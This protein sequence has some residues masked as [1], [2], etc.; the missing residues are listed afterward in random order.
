ELALDLSRL[1][2]ATRA[3]GETPSTLGL[4][5]LRRGDQLRRINRFLGTQLEFHCGARDRARMASVLARADR[6]L[7]GR[8][9]KP[10]RPQDPAQVSC[11][12]ETGCTGLGQTLDNRQVASIHAHL[13]SKPVLLAH[14]PHVARTRV[15]SLAQV[16][17]DASYGCYDYLDL[18][19]S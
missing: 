10:S 19:S 15:T 13:K 1:K 8:V 18:W 16:P 14:A 2:K 7:P 4:H 6:V 9:R 17:H 11:I 3:L 12:R 5:G